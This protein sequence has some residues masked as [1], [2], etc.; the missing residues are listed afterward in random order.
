MFK[1][2]SQLWKGEDFFKQ[3]FDDFK[4]MLDDTEGMFTSV[5]EKII[6]DKASP[7]L[8]DRT[9]KSDK[10]VNRLQKEIRR[11]IVEHLS[12]RQSDAPTC[13]LL[14]SVVKD[15]ERLGDYAKN[16]FEISSLLDKP[17]DKN[18]YLNLF[19]SIEK[20]I[21]QLFQQTKQAFI[22]L[23]KNEAKK[24]WLKEKKIAKRCDSIIRELART[25]NISTNEAVCLTLI[26]RHFKRI[27]AHLTNI[28]TSVIVPLSDLDYFDEKMLNKGILDA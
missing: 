2:L 18:I 19:D 27:G 12:I 20:D 3:V 5:C 26:A 8:K 10:N 25:S 1:R 11:R 13:L 24:S 6:A 7:D 28:A 14:M 9:Y 17:L 21:L 15:A 22:D 4:T 16:L 23:D